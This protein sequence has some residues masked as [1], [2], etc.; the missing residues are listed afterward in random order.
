MAIA[1]S[2]VAQ[3]VENILIKTSLVGTVL[4]PHQYGGLNKADHASDARAL[5]KFL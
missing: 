1:A 3:I 2:S 5:M 4:S